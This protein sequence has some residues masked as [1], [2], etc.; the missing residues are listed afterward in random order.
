MFVRNEFECICMRVNLG[1]A[2]S[3]V[4]LI[5]HRPRTFEYAIE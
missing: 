5:M 4:N 3:D 2:S 1:L